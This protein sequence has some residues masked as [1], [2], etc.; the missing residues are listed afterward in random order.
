M[1]RLFLCIWRVILLYLIY[2]FICGVIIPAIPVNVSHKTRD[3]IKPADFYANQT[4]A[5]RIVLVE[6]SPDGFDTRIQIIREAQHT[7][8]ISYH[9]VEWGKTAEYFFGAVMDAADRG[10][11]VRFIIDDFIGGLNEHAPD[12]AMAMVAHENIE[13]KS[14]NKID[15]L[16]PWLAN[17]R[18][19]DKYIISDDRLLLLGGRNIGDKYFDSFDF[20][21]VSSSDRDVLVYN[22]L[23]GQ[24]NS[25]S[26][27]LSQV[28]GYMDEIFAHPL[29]KCP[30]KKLSGGQQS[31][32]ESAHA[33]LLS[34]Y[35][36]LEAIRPD[37]FST[38]KV[39]WERKTVA[40][41]KITLISNPIHGNK[42]EPIVG[43]TL[44]VLA[45]NAQKSVIMQ[46]PYTVAKAPM[47]NVFAAIAQNVPQA[48]LITNSMAS[49]P[50]LPA[51]SHYISRRKA[52]AKT[53]VHIMEYQGRNS[54]HAKS[55]L[56]DGRL[57]ATG[58]L[59]LDERSLYLD[60]E[61]MLVIDSQPFYAQLSSAVDAIKAGSIEVGKDNSYLPSDVASGEVS[62]AKTALFGLASFFTRI[63][64]HL[65]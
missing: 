12:V 51:F 23:Q 30:F 16:R 29:T 33:R 1:K 47:L 54:I 8:D 13:Y 55:F 5:D 38:A 65:I 21:G 58:S 20:D 63:I 57:C 18:L 49:T 7:L 48:E 34:S 40:T 2:V 26:S 53:G 14:Y 60:T 36:N 39:D 4:G 15:L 43:Y 31:K 17:S 64:G 10:V 45:K 59:N 52:I 44:S 6:N 41:N 3:T 42:K 11:K 9:C 46:S 32:A 62:W 35:E 37:L 24:A 25:N 22:T 56:I 28:R 27:V 61:T 50:N 19:H